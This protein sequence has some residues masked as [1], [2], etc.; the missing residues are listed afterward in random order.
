MAFLPS[1]TSRSLT[2]HPLQ[3]KVV[4]EIFFQLMVDSDDDKLLAVAA[5]GLAK[6]VLAGMVSAARTDGCDEDPKGEDDT[7]ERSMLELVRSA[8]LSVLLSNF[9]EPFPFADDPQPHHRLHA[10]GQLV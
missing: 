9:A 8:A 6:L 3:V 10:S 5:H 7:N 4:V 2:M 1:F